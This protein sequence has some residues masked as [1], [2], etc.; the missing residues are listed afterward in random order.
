MFRMS[1][2]TCSMWHASKVEDSGRV[3]LDAEPNQTQLTTSKTNAVG[4]CEMCRVL[5]HS[6]RPIRLYLRRL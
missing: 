6:Q 3:A 5:I 2:D 1:H 4:M